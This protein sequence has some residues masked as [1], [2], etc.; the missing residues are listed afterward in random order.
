MSVPKEISVE[1]LKLHPVIQDYRHKEK[2]KQRDERVAYLVE[3]W[4]ERKLNR[5]EVVPADEGG[6]WVIRGGHRLSAARVLR[7]PVLPCDVIYGLQDGPGDLVEATLGREDSRG[8]TA[9]N[10]FKLRLEARLEPESSIE[11]VL[12]KN[13]ARTASNPV[14]GYSCVKSLVRSF[15]SGTLFQAIFVIES[16]WKGQQYG[17]SGQVLDALNLFL[18]VYRG[19]PG[20]DVNVLA[21]KLAS[22]DALQLVVGARTRNQALR[23]GV[24]RCLCESFRDIYNKGRSSKA[25][26]VFKMPRKVA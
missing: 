4:D 13:G 14:V 2:P 18:T 15:E 9:Y 16:A 8:W 7:L 25:I 19:N 5:L 24:A 12:N 26:P 23:L 21:E 17:R 6:Y 10:V 11:A 3:N 22:R 20:F 1:A